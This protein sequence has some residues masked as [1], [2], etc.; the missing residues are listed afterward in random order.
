VLSSNYIHW[1]QLTKEQII[2]DRLDDTGNYLSLATNIAATILS[3]YRLWDVRKFQ[4]RSHPASTGQRRLF[5]LVETGVIFCIAQLIAFVFS[6][7]G[8]TKNREKLNSPLLLFVGV[9]VSAVVS[10]SPLYPTLVFVIVQQ[11]NSIAD[12][13]SIPPISS[14]RFN[15][16]ASESDPSAQAS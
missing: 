1:T 16:S 5:L 15:R 11:Q 13:Y 6:Q 9:T 14:L 8:S 12:M 2:G 7:L 3:G 10:L 4:N